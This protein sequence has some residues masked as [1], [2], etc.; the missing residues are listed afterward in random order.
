MLMNP[1]VLKIHSLKRLYHMHLNNFLNRRY[2]G[3]LRV[4]LSQCNGARTQNDLV[5]EQ[6]LCSLTG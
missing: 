4:F 2:E 1:I 6:K 3:F 5:G